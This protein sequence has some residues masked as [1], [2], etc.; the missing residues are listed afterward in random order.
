MTSVETPNSSDPYYLFCCYLSEIR[1]YIKCVCTLINIL[2][3]QFSYE[4]NT[5]VLWTPLPFTAGQL[6]ILIVLQ[7]SKSLLGCT[8]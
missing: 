4:V 7:D 6:S 5:Q 8:A 3:I 1:A 2:N